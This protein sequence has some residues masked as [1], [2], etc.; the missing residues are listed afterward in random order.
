MLPTPIMF[1]FLFLGAGESGKSTIVKQMKWV[2]SPVFMID[3]WLNNQYTNDVINRLHS[4]SEQTNEQRVFF[5]RG[6]KTVDD[7]TQS[8]K[9]LL[10]HWHH[11]H[12]GLQT[13]ERSNFRAFS[14]RFDGFCRIIHESGFTSEDFKQYRPVVYSNTI[15][16]LVAI[17]RAMPNLGVAFG[18]EDREASSYQLEICFHHLWA[19][20]QIGQ[21]KLSLFW[22]RVRSL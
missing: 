2:P 6:W 8:R 10:N 1:F 22:M 16:S 11:V 15:Q 20:H 19:F 3:F 18:S 17:L 13:L 14:K 9:G 5:G 4:N 12:G 7:V 21:T